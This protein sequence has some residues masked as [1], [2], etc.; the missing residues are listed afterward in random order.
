MK[1]WIQTDEK[2]EACEGRGYSTKTID[3]FHPE[4]S[5]CLKCNCTGFKQKMMDVRIGRY[6]HLIVLDENMWG[7]GIKE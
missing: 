2:C 1:I 7:K 5:L 6:G 4:R 3:I